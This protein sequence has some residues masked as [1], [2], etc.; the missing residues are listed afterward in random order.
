MKKLVSILLVIVI[1]FSIASVTCFSAT[2][3]A[4]DKEYL[5]IDSFKELHYLTQPND[6]RYYYDEVY[7][8]HIDENDIESEIDWAIIYASFYAGSAASIKKLVLDRVITNG[9]IEVYYTVGW[10]LYDAKTKE[11][12]SIDQVDVTKYA[13][14]E[15]GMAV[16]RVGNPL[17]DADHDG[18]LSILD[19]TYIQ[20][21]L[22][23]LCEYSPYDDLS[24]Y[25]LWGTK[26]DRPLDYISD[27]DGDGDRSILDA[28][29]I[30]MKL[31][32]LDVPVATA[33]E[34]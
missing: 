23:K 19:A 1:L 5:F 26:Y 31:A 8:H 7:Y 6:M 15:Q 18:E 24:D 10:A 21:V 27:I 29:T 11:F 34:V 4:G 20:R 3:D 22:A 32:K 33:D 30:Q 16:A 2:N 14:F 25:G 17:G 13:D 9:S 12:I 28:T